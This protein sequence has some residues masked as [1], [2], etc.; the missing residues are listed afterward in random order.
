MELVARNLICLLI[1]QAVAGGAITCDAPI[2]AFLALCFTDAGA[3][4][5]AD[6]LLVTAAIINI[7]V[8]PNKKLKKELADATERTADTTDLTAD[9]TER[10]PVEAE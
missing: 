7:F 9:A 2:T 5:C 10:T 1:P 4:L 8:K 3:W 6:F